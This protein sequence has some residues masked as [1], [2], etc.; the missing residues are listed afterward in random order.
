MNVCFSWTK[1]LTH[2][3]PGKMTLQPMVYAA[4]Q[5]ASSRFWIVGK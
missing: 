4:I 1:P 2:D 5:N 3:E